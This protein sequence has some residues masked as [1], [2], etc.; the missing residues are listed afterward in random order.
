[1]ILKNLLAPVGLGVLSAVVPGIDANHHEGQYSKGDG[2]VDTRAVVRSVLAAED[3]GS[4]D[5]ADA[6]EADE[7]S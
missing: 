6:A 3:E 7:C 4:S 2:R 1:M 5:T